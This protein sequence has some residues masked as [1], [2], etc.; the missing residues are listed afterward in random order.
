M[1]KAKVHVLSLFVDIP[2]HYVIDLGNKCEEFLNSYHD[3]Q[4]LDEMKS[5]DEDLD[6]VHGANHRGESG[7]KPGAMKRNIHKQAKN[8]AHTNRN[9]FV[10]FSV[11]V[12]VVIGYFLAMFILGN[13]YIGDIQE[14]S[15]EMANS[16]RLEATFSF[17][18]NAQREM[19]YNPDKPVLK[20]NSFNAA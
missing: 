9:F 19:L 16:A 20:G 3:E 11:A 2:N 7:G 10:Q 6:L 18:Q 8:T 5:E 13:N 1:N 14:L 4:K 12:A 17:A 15:K